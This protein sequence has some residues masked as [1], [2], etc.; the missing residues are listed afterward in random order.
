MSAGRLSYE[1]PSWKVVKKGVNRSRNRP[2]PRVKMSLRGPVCPDPPR[3]GLR[4]AKLQC[5]VRDTDS[6]RCSYDA[7]STQYGKLAKK[8]TATE[9]LLS[10]V[11]LQADA[12]ESKYVDHGA[13]G[14]IEAKHP[15]SEM[16]CVLFVE[17]GIGMRG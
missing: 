9:P 12:E 3:A 13:Q 6:L 7:A 14:N 17:H 8:W 2:L 11:A 16:K 10:L 5:R 15:R 4:Y 1:G